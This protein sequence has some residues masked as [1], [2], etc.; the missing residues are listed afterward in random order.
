M[1]R[2][3]RESECVSVCVCLRQSDSEENEW[4]IAAAATVQREVN[5]FGFWTLGVTWTDEVDA[6][7]SF[8]KLRIT[9][10]CNRSLVCCHEE[11]RNRPDWEG[12]GPAT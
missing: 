7:I 8:V 10:Q 4:P 1:T 5:R 11:L 6:Q 2:Q 3:E 12:R 9:L